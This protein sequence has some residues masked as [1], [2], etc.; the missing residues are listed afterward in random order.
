MTKRLSEGQKKELVEN[1]GTA[2]GIGKIEQ[3]NNE[4]DAAKAVNEAVAA[5]KVPETYK[6]PVD[7]YGFPS[8]IPNEEFF[9]AVNHGL[10]S[11]R[12]GT[13]PVMRKALQVK[14]DIQAKNP[15]RVLDSFVDAFNNERGFNL[16]QQGLSEQEALN[17]LIQGYSK[18]T[19]KLRLGVPLVRGRDIL[20][21]T[22]DFYR[23]IND[24]KLDGIPVAAGQIERDI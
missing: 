19:D 20:L 11:Y 23:T 21:N 3:R 16:R 6:V 4:R 14:E 18:S 5:G 17:E 10:L 12:Y 24:P 15:K 9:N 8:S 7:D 1:V 2:L 13:N 22:Q